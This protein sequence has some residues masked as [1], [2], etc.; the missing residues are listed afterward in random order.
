MEMGVER[1]ADDVETVA[2]ARR[3][4]G[5][6]GGEL[7][8]VAPAPR[9][10]IERDETGAAGWPGRGHR[11][12]LPQVQPLAVFGGMMPGWP[13]A[14][15]SGPSAEMRAVDGQHAVGVDR[16]PEPVHPPRRR[17]EGLPGRLDPEP[18]VA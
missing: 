11:G 14:T 5:Q 4:L 13:S 9:A 16:H 7:V 10:G 3:P 15:G 12:I 2:K 17:P 1:S 18:V 6:Q 8:A